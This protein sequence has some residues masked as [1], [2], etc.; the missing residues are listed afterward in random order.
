MSTLAKHRPV[1]K[2]TTVESPVGPLT[3]AWQ[4]GFIT[5]LH[6][7]DQRHS[8]PDMGD[9]E[10][11]ESVFGA[12]VEQ[13]EEYFAG[14]RTTFDLPMRP[15]GT[16]FQHRVWAG[17]R[18]I[19]YGRTISYAEL[20]GR[21]GNPKACRAV[22]LANGRNP[23]GIIVPCHRVIGANGTLVGYGGGLDRK[24]WLLEHERRNLPATR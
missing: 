1:T 8:P 4:E 6:M 7:H 5:G 22:G 12:A 15:A 10:P 14:R 3:L 17:L 9:W 13:L 19:P 18:A 20:A 16:E 24:R 23:I 2:T 11:D 21:I